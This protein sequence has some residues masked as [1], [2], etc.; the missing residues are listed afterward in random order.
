[1][2]DVKVLTRADTPIAEALVTA[3]Q[4]R[5]VGQFRRMSDSRILKAVLYGN[6]TEGR[7]KQG[8][9]KLCLKDMLK[10]H[11]K[12]IRICPDTW[13]QAAANKSNW[14]APVRRSIG[15]TEGK[16]LKEYNEPMKDYTLLYQQPGMHALFVTLWP[17]C[18]HAG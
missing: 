3:S 11:I 6:L 8:G 14:R 1:M 5:W 17:T 7:R 10:R 2:P 15:S 12:N 18:L 9:Q 4:L 16:R 13:K